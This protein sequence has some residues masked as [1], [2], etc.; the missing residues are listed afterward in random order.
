MAI[1]EKK[2]QI[3][4]STKELTNFDF[5]LSI[6]FTIIMIGYDMIGIQTPYNA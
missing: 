2:G 6:V 4:N 3:Q 1:T 5:E